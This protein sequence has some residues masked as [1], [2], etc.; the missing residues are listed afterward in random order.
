MRYHL[1]VGMQWHVSD[2]FQLDS[3]IYCN[4][5]LVRTQLSQLGFW[6]V[7]NLSVHYGLHSVKLDSLIQFEWYPW[8]LELSWNSCFWHDHC[9]VLFII[10]WLYRAATFYCSTILPI[11]CIFVCILCE[12]VFSIP[13]PLWQ[14]NMVSEP[15]VG[16]SSDLSKTIFL[17]DLAW[18]LSNSS[19]IQH[20]TR[21]QGLPLNTPS[22]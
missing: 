22:K 1:L 8:E 19:K 11:L 5:T 18:K 2:L 6:L 13:R 17:I 7:V 4:P 16:W 20:C 12:T 10:H 15:M 3:V 14:I 9:I 21:S